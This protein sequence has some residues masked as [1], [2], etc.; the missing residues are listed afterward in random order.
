MNQNIKIAK[1]LVKLAK[2]LTSES[3]TNSN[4]KTAKKIKASGKIRI[5]DNMFLTGSVLWGKI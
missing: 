3:F 4:I 5:F 1:E 2:N